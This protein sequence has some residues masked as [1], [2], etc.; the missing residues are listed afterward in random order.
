MSDS[1]LNMKADS[2]PIILMRTCSI[3]KGFSPLMRP[4][5]KQRCL[6]QK[7]CFDS[8][9]YQYLYFLTSGLLYSQT[10]NTP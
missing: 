9:F 8:T 10:A 7:P 2:N 4:K 1:L 3:V 5:D 6:S